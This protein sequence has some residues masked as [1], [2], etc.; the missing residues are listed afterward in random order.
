VKRLVKVALAALVA[1][2]LTPAAQA[3]A[4]GGDFG[5]A[6][7]EGFRLKS[8][9]GR[10]LLRFGL[11]AGLK[12]EPIWTEGVPQS[13]SMFAFLRPII[14]GNLTE[15]WIR[16]RVS[17]ELAQGDPFL[18]DGF[19]DIQPSKALG[20][21]FGQQGTPVSRH[22]ALGPQS[23]F[24]PDFAPVANYFWSGREKG[25]TVY[26]TTADDRLNYYAGLYDGS[27][28][29]QKTSA[30]GNNVAE[31]RVTFNPMGAV[32]ANEY[33]FTPD[34]DPLPT[35]V[36]FTA[37]GYHGRIQTDEYSYNSS[38]SPLTPTQVLKSDEVTVGGVDAWFQKGNVI[39]FA[40]AYKRRLNPA[41]GSAYD[42]TGVWGQIV[43]SAYRNRLGLGVRVNWIDPS[44]NLSN[45]EAAIFEGQAS[46]LLQ[47]P[48]LV[49][50]LRYALENQ[51]TP[52]AASLGSFTLPFAQGT[53]HVATLQLT[54]SF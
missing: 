25:L 14:R 8:A 52:D 28:I 49:L 2:G 36:S 16:Y 10:N 44:S 42:S 3:Q 32:N 33:P 38:N 24:F 19:V 45:D 1:A 13:R 39:A 11:Q 27:L 48:E 17:M 9:D 50:K 12:L 15:E 53:T 6:P 20:F 40:E 21:V 22:N 5:F 4:P 51:R 31:A 7:G 47:V 18:I 37:Q 35:R 54:M 43:T 30:A 46:W 26:G 23:I 41:A 29:D 34:G